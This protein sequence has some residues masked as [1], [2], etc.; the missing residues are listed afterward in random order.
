MHYILLSIALNLGK[1]NI[2]LMKINDLKSINLDLVKISSEE[3]KNL[4][5][6]SIA[7]EITINNKE[8]ETITNDIKTNNDNN[9]IIAN[10]EN[11]ISQESFMN[12]LSEFSV[13]Y[14]QSNNFAELLPEDEVGNIIQE[15]K[16]EEGPKF[17]DSIKNKLI[18]LT[19]NNRKKETITGSQVEGPSIIDNI[20]EKIF[21]D[22][23]EGSTIASNSSVGVKSQKQDEN[24]IKKNTTN[25]IETIKDKTEKITD[26]ITDKLLTNKD[27]QKTL[28]ELP[29][30]TN[31]DNIV[32]EKDIKIV[33]N[34]FDS[35][36]NQALKDE[37]KYKNI[38]TQFVSDEKNVEYVEDEDYKKFL[39]DKEVETLL[40]PEKIIIPVI[41]PKEKVIS[42]FKTQK[43]PSELLEPRSFENRHIP[44]IMQNKEKEDILYKVVEYG[45]IED[46][47][48]I[49]REEDLDINSMLSNQYTLLTHATKFKQYD[50]MKYLI[51]KGADVNK[52][53]S[54]L[55]TPLLIAI[56]N[57]DLESVDLLTKSNANLEKVDVM[58]RTPLILAIEKG[59][60]RIADYLID[61]GANTKAKNAM[62]EEVLDIC[63]RLDRTS[64]KE[65]ILNLARKQ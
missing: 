55:D 28:K 47:K 51:H 9:S 36:L 13:P 54:R 14:V 44:K 12:D 20:K 56:R 61:N 33:G 64:I 35:E 18:E 17:L 49:I 10:D 26:K 39:N 37:N 63:I 53:D 5:D 31:K 40:K 23:K 34:L 27:G 1:E 4:N 46:S 50:I 43:V 48:A 7:K 59:Y 11:L 45:L 62:D 6:N 3:N 30:Q 41:T 15:Q 2:D 58:K 8:Q 38:Y 65:K 25:L 16:E 32:N 60:N 22:K 42:S 21:G 19:S 29:D 24:I 57:N 52:R